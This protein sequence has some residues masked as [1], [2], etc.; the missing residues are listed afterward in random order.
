MN[1]HFENA[2]CELEDENSIHQKYLSYIMNDIFARTD[3]PRLFE[4][5]DSE[6]S[7]YAK[8][9]L[10]LL[11]QG[12]GKI[13]GTTDFTSPDYPYHAAVVPGIIQISEEEDF[14][15]GIF[16]IDMDNRECLFAHAISPMG[17]IQ[18]DQRLDE[19]PIGLS[20]PCLCEEYGMLGTRGK[21]IL[22][23]FQKY[24]VELLPIQDMQ[25]QQPE[26]S[27]EQGD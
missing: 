25:G 1:Q 21:S 12:L 22:A 14:Y 17:F 23:D 10:N 4:S 13:Y 24:E 18:V 15:I 7:V 27:M 2:L 3:Y 19:L 8:G 16:S 20:A 11:H 26:E 9:I 6:D 5:Y